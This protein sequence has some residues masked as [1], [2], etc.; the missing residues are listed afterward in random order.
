[1][2]KS[3]QYILKKCLI[4]NSTTCCNYLMLLVTEILVLSHNKISLYILTKA[5]SPI[6]PGQQGD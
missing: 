3:V 1:M 5:V 2:V 6:K 4:Q